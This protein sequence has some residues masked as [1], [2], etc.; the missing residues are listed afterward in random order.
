MRRVLTLSIVAIALC[1]CA[2]DKYLTATGGSRADGI[3]EMS[4][5]TGIFEQPVIHL[6]EAQA[7]ARERC[8]VWGYDTADAFGGE[9]R[10][11]QAY[12]G[13]GNCLRWF[14]TVS[15]QCA[16]GMTK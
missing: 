9:K 13:Y 10:Q 7:S 2:S 14:V 1:A 15:F 8:A 3:I 12:N 4:Y 16:G 5:E 11:C 6:A